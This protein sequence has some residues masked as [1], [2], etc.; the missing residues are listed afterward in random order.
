MDRCRYAVYNEDGSLAELKGFEI[1][2]RGELKLIKVFQEQIFPAFL[3]GS[4]LMECYQAVG[5]VADRWLEVL[6]TEGK[7]LANDEVID[8]I[9]E[10]KT[11]SK[12]VQESGAVKSMSITT[13]NRMAEFLG[14][15]LLKDRGL[16][17]HMVVAEKP[18]GEPP[19]SRAIPISIFNAP[20]E[21][22]KYWLKRW[23]KDPSHS[24]FD[25]RGV[26][27]WSYYKQ[28]L[29]A[30]ILKIV[31]IPAAFQDI[32]NPV[33][34]IDLPEWLRRRVVASQDSFKQRKIDGM[35]SRLQQP[36][37]GNP[38]QAP[39]S[40][41]A[42]V[43][44]QNSSKLADFMQLNTQQGRR[45]SQPQ[46]GINDQ[47]GVS[48]V[49]QDAGGGLVDLEDIVDEMQNL[50]VD[51]ST[52]Q[53]TTAAEGSEHVSPG[54]RSQLIKDKAK[55][56]RQQQQAQL[57]ADKETAEHSSIEHAVDGT[58]TTTTST[59]APDVSAAT[60]VQLAQDPK[61]FRQ[62]QLSKWRKLREVSMP[63]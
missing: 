8:Y 31:C 7:E 48:T 61:K 36:Q 28:R 1:K 39:G 42:V 44:S 33:P 15:G 45:G 30:A 54:N 52:D 56:R 6:R 50:N 9:S 60:L 26:I 18:L 13:A 19:T 57:T 49:N 4:S 35:F 62:L 34:D 24:N 27:D 25:I 40:V 20:E 11:M 2:R 38:Q 21:T 59:A 37:Q 16:A 32:P 53:S 5:A 10:S 22:K 46:S 29:G 63:P 51:K 17:C 47:G 3:Q 12:S 55:L 14:K 23:L 41:G 58:A 43:P